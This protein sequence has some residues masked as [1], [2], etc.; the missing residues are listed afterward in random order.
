[1]SLAV[2]L[3]VFSVTVTVWLPVSPHGL[4]A[5]PALPSQAILWVQPAH[6]EENVSLDRSIVIAFSEPMNSSSIMLMTIP[7][8]MDMTFTWTGVN[9]LTVDHA[10]FLECILYRIFIDWVGEPD[11]GDVPNPWS[12]RTVCLL[13]S[14]DDLD[15]D[16]IDPRLCISRTSPADGEDNVSFGAPIVVEFCDPVNT[17]FSWFLL[18]P[19]AD[20]YS[21]VWSGG[22]RF[23]TIQHHR[24]FEPC[25]QYWATIGSDSDSYAWTFFTV[26]PFA[27]ADNLTIR[28]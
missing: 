5:P 11:S 28:R 3:T 22:D 4:S 25:T 7:P 2:V 18:V 19:P 15:L 14:G 26:C 1:M 6:G 9:I 13:L 24:P 10:P 8:L 23:L 12:F 20:P 17:T 21:F 27:P 16:P